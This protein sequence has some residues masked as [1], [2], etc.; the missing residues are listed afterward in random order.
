MKQSSY[1]SI[2][3]SN[4]GISRIKLNDPSTYNSLS[5]GMLKSLISAFKNFDKDEKT[6]VIII[7]GSGKGFSAGHNLKEVRSLKGVKDRRK[8]PRTPKIRS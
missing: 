3:G 7:E 5:L 2:Q 6:R 1:I 8:E 4:N